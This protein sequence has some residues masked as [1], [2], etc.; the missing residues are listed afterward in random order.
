MS[1]LV[2]VGERWWDIR[3]MRDQNLWVKKAS[4]IIK[5]EMS[6]ILFGRKVW[7]EVLFWVEAFDMNLLVGVRGSK[8]NLDLDLDLDLDLENRWVFE[9]FVV[10]PINVE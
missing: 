10:V 3:V 2:L 4:V 7:L 9:L 6:K 8:R 1:G 5:K